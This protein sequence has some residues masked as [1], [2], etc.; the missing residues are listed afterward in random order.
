MIQVLQLIV[1]FIKLIYGKI[2]VSLYVALYLLHVLVFY[3]VFI[4]LNRS[5]I[6]A[7]LQSIAYGFSCQIAH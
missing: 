3:D 4:D 6:F 2:F 7:V 1:F 5:Y